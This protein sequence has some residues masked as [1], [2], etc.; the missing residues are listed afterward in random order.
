MTEFSNAPRPLAIGDILDGTFRLYRNNFL[1]FLGIAA[2][3]QV[4]LLIFQVA[5]Q[6]TAGMQFTTDYLQLIENI[7]SLDPTID[8]FNDLPLAS[9]GIYLIGSLLFGL[10]QY[11]IVQQLMNGAL[12]NAVAQRYRGEPI[13]VLGS[14]SFSLTT[15]FNL[16]GSGLIVGVIVVLVS[17]V[18]SAIGVG[19]IFLLATLAEGGDS[20]GAI[21]SAILAIVL[22]FVLGLAVIFALIYILM[23]FIFVPQAVVLEE[24]GAFTALGRS[25]RLVGGS[26]WRLLGITLLIGLLVYI[27]VGIPVGI[28]SFVMQLTLGSVDDPLQN[29]ALVT[30]LNTFMTSIAQMI[31]LPV[32][33]AAMTLL[34]FD[35]RVRREG[36]DIAQRL[37]EQPGLVVER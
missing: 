33:W 36:F 5:F 30:A 32:Q 12:I 4:P 8:S 17:F 26:F 37:Q 18:A 3:A 11:G 19:S 20:G 21:L 7:G 34:Y 29:F 2:L 31:T 9:V 23:R 15:A 1:L 35:V 28:L 27:L 25:W 22:T 14:Y 10:F 24:Q 16:I 6:A 13:S